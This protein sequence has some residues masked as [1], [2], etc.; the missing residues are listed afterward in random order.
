MTRGSRRVA[1]TATS[2]RQGLLHHGKSGRIF[3]GE[4]KDEG[5]EDDPQYGIRSQAGHPDQVGHESCRRLIWEPGKL[6]SELREKKELEPVGN[7]S[8]FNAATGRRTDRGSV[9]PAYSYIGSALIKCSNDGGPGPRYNRKEDPGSSIFSM[10]MVYGC[11][12]HL[13]TSSEKQVTGRISGDPLPPFKPSWA[14]HP[15]LPPGVRAPPH[16][17]D[18]PEAG[19]GEIVLPPLI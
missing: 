3:V 11:Y 13:L 14:E 5:D 17:K 16:A 6:H 2:A 18:E 12:L 7:F 8:S 1:G 4:V 9:S 10:L 19:L 15:S